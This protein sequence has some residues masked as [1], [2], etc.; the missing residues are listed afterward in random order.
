MTG[1]I[2][3]HALERLNFPPGEPVPKRLA[4]CKTFLRLES[5][6]I[7]M[8]HDAGE[9]GLEVVHAR[10]A[11]IDVLLSH[12]F[13]YAISEWTRHQETLPAPVSLVALGGYGR[14]ELSPLSDIDIMFLFP[15]KVKL[16][17]VKPLQEH[18]TNEILYLLWDCGLKVGHS[19][20][21]VDDVFDEAR[22]DIQT[23]TALL[24]S[25][26]VAGS[27]TLYES[28]S[29]A[30]ENFYR[31]ENPR[32]YITARL[33][34][35]AA[36]REKYGGTVFLQEPDIKNGVGGLRDY[37]NALWMA[38]VKL[39]IKQMSELAAQGHL[40]R[41]QLR[42]FERAYD[43]LLRV[44]NELHFTSRYA[45]DL[46]NLE[47]QPRVAFGLGYT[48][49]N[50]LGRVEQFMHH[51]YR[52]A[53]SIFRVSRIVET[54]LA[55]TLDEDKGFR[56]PFRDALR[57]Y[58]YQKSKRIDGFVVR[59]QELVADKPDV[60]K[61]DPARLIRVFRHGQ[62][63]EA[64]PDFALRSLIRESLPLITKRVINSP[65]ATI[66]FRAI[67]SETGAVFPTLDLMH[68][69]GVLGRFIPEFDQLTC[70]VQHEFY[71][72]YTADIHTLHAIRELDRIFT[73]AE[74]ITLKY[75]AALHETPDPT[76]LYLI[77]LLHDI[78]KGQGIQGHAE[79]GVRISGPILERLGVDPASREMV[80]FVIKNHLIMARFWQR[81]DVDDPQTAIAFA[82]QVDDPD[83]LRYLYVHTF[84]DA[85]GTSASLW[86]SYKDTLH[87]SLFRATLDRLIH[88]EALESRNSERTKMKHQELV[89]KK[90]PGI[91]TEEISAHFSLLPERYFVHTDTSEIT[92][93][94][95]MVN[96]LLHSITA[97]D[98]VGSLRPVIDWKD[99]LNRSL[100]VVNVVTWDRAGL[101][102]KLA[103]AFSVAGLNILGA[104]VISRTDHIAIDTFYVVE[105]GR[106]IVQNQSATE[107]F[108]QTVDQALIQNRDL[109][110]DIL[111]Q[112]KKYNQGRYTTSS[113]APGEVL[114]SSFPPTVDVY[115]EL[116]MHR[117]IVEIQAHD[118]I[119]LLYRL[120]K[121]IYDHGFDITFARIGTERG[122]ALDTFY[123]E[124]ANHEIT[125]DTGR[126]HSL[127]DAL[128]AVIAQP[129]TS[130]T[131]AA[132]TVAAKA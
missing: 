124:S 13:N 85:R 10:A 38:R 105:P 120:A 33:E 54:R 117:T 132:Q 116:S 1:R 49:S 6:M 75:R 123:I 79:S 104:K 2:I 43:F 65:D 27:E 106:G 14:A 112:A 119:G 92:L 108:A 128:S 40:R 36:R 77:L 122:I 94:I 103:G 126:L 114:Q 61:E 113:S 28:F 97:A 80:A 71:H 19:T 130:Q 76:L 110:P 115:H 69:L 83:K 78:G 4:A 35:Q 63:L 129:A 131:V 17:A 87:T 67:L 15:S 48:N 99:D 89:T 81:R 39:G 58:R 34:D 12:L 16:A 66:S 82:E 9:S 53:Q 25:R 70:L 26:L 125:E 46:L 44:R 72:R 23:K 121:T 100:T 42:D 96:K 41:N 47:A 30:F 127:R 11:M 111:A 64:R 8:R 90:I 68:E 86:N 29:K 7:R 37:Q 62:Q 107:T 31:N 59:G 84:C 21:S 101:F 57:A 56:I 74:P 50:L 3:K 73:E 55:L 52:S 18:L 51:Y 88:G 118:Q 93:H 98:S 60:F 45:T 32:G 20:R 109:Y 5:A 24:E 102:Y 22:K 91:S 95:Q